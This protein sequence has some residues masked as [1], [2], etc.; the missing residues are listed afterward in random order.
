[1]RSMVEPLCATKMGKQPV[2]RRD[3]FISSYT[4]GVLFQV[5]SSIMQWP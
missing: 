2:R 4:N 3:E 5:F 1:M